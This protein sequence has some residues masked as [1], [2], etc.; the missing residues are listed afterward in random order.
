MKF[1]VLFNKTLDFG[2]LSSL[3]DVR[4]HE[5]LL[6]T[7]FIS[8]G[9]EKAHNLWEIK[10]NKNKTWHTTKNVSVYFLK[11]HRK[12]QNMDRNSV[13]ITADRCERENFLLRRTQQIY[14]PQ[15]WRCMCCISCRLFANLD[16]SHLVFFSGRDR[17]NCDVNRVSQTRTSSVSIASWAERRHIAQLR[18]GVPS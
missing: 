6:A 16:F 7:H 5:T 9:P 10:I 13:K 2:H 18:S 8:S 11:H 4:V 17:V 12:I 14:S 3:H 15:R 1:N